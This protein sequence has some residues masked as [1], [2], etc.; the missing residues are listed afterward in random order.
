MNSTVKKFFMKQPLMRKVLLSL[1][2]VILGA[3]F[4]FGWRTLVLMAI[5]TFFG[6][7]TE[8]LFKRKSHKP[9]TEAVIVTSVLFT[10]TLPISTPLWVGAVGI[11]FGVAFAKE[12]FGGYGFNVFNP[13]LAGRT[14][15]YVCFPEFLTVHWN[16]AS[17]S[18]PG[19]FI[20]YMTPTIEAISGATPLTLLRQTGE[21]L[22]LRQLF[23]G[24]VSGSMGET[25]GLLILIAAIIL[26]TTKTIDWKLLAAPIIGFVAMGS[27]LHLVSPDTV[28]GPLYG[29]F[30][31]GFL[32]VSV[33]FVTEPVTAPKTTA[34][35][36]IYGLLIGIITILIRTFGIFVGGAMFAVL[37]MNTF[38]PIMDEGIKYLRSVRRRKQ[39]TA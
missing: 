25:S 35:K 11:I 37:I 18:F 22:P 34:A 1:I 2:P 8:Y 28:P 39:V 36:W 13:A 20:A 30:S 26:L 38:V 7:A 9:V 12:V 21:V 19:G 31:G 17:N 27:L 29:L 24:N 3:I 23:L 10:L 33:F 32:L 4:F 14:F 16:V 5:I 6:I 15:L